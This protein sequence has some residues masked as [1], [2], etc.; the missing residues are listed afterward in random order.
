M[1]FFNIKAN[2]NTLNANKHLEITSDMLIKFIMFSHLN[3]DLPFELTRYDGEKVAVK[4][5]YAGIKLHL[6]LLSTQ[7]RILHTM[8]ISEDTIDLKLYKSCTYLSYHHGFET[9][10]YS[11]L[12][13]VAR[14][15]IKALFVPFYTP[16][17]GCCIP[18]DPDAHLIGHSWDMY[19]RLVDINKWT[20]YSKIELVELLHTVSRR[21]VD[22]HT[23]YRK[24]PLTDGYLY[25]LVSFFVA[26][27]ELARRNR[28]LSDQFSYESHSAEWCYG[29]VLKKQYQFLQRID[30]DNYIP[31]S[32]LAKH[33]VVGK[34]CFGSRVHV[35]RYN[36][37][38]GFQ[39]LMAL[40]FIKEAVR[41]ES[42]YTDI[43]EEGLERI[44]MMD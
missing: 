42:F 44:E 5:Y 23:S 20:T 24:P 38:T 1:N 39:L 14:D 7:S 8:G 11:S 36:P 19:P 3:D 40:L 9:R 33:T 18:G 28:R 27:D 16:Y 25:P 34:G 29:N 41:D 10:G 32:E 26:F 15:G 13:S 37:N 4:D 43:G 31:M 21:I 12:G 17:G 2:I 30:R 35:D 22:I 6:G